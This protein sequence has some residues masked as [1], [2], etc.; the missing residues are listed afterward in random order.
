MPAMDEAMLIIAIEM[1]QALTEFAE[2][3]EESGSDMR[4]IRALLA[5]WESAFRRYRAEPP[6]PGDCMFLRFQAS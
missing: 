2:A 3:G 4:D 5:D 1:A 6:K